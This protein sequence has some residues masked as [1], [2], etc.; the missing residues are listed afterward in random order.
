MRA[1]IHTPHQRH[2]AAQ[3]PT[4]PFSPSAFHRLP[5]QSSAFHP[6]PNGEKTRL[7]CAFRRDNRPPHTSA[8][9]LPS[10]SSRCDA[11][12][13]ASAQLRAPFARVRIRVC[14]AH[15]V[16][17]TSPSLSPLFFSNASANAS[18]KASANASELFLS[19]SLSLS[20]PLPLPL[21]RS[22]RPLSRCCPLLSLERARLSDVQTRVWGMNLNVAADATFFF[23]SSLP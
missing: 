20:L 13:C 17:F 10:L 12:L 1:H 6:P 23:D 11:L 19:L 2:G 3:R 21:P 18:A 4:H 8:L 7:C 14:V 22:M 15:R 5:F 9:S 16:P